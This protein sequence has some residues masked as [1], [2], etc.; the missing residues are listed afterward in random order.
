MNCSPTIA[1]AL[2]LLA[3]VA[4]VWILYKAQKENLGMLFK[5]AGWLVVV[6]ALGSMI[7]CSVFCIHGCGPDGACGPESCGS[8]EVHKE[9]RIFKGGHGSCEMEASG[10][11]AKMG[12]EMEGKGC[13]KEEKE[14]E[15]ACCSGHGDHHYEEKE[16]DTVVVKK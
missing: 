1:I 13:C 6:V 7:C 15:E 12:C 2:L 14:S 11:G 4:G 5:A 8:G 16:V 9:V 10:C 3:F